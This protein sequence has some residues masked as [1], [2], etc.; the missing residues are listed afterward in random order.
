MKRSKF[1]QISAMLTMAGVLVGFHTSG[2]TASFTP[3]LDASTWATNVT[4]TVVTE[5]FSDTTLLSGF[6]VSNGTIASGEF[7]ATASTQF[8]DAGNPA[9]QFAS[10]SAFGADFD[11]GPSGPGDGLFMVFNFAD[12]SSGNYFLGNPSGGAF[13]GFFGIIADSAISSVRF[14]SPVTGVEEFSADNVRFLAKDE[15]P[16]P[17][18]GSMA[19]AGLAL[20][21]AFVTRRSRR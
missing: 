11:L 15:R 16:L 2:L 17:E 6:S 3:Y 14:D 7:T 20:V 8:N 1:G 12:G 10:S 19:L 5:D 4:G 9:W 21:A 18:P 13:S